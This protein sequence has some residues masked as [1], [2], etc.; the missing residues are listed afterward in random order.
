MASAKSISFTSVRCGLSN[1]LESLQREFRLRS[2]AEAGNGSVVPR[3]LGKWFCE[4]R[5]IVLEPFGGA[6]LKRKSLFGQFWQDSCHLRVPSH[7]WSR[8]DGTGS[9]G[10]STTSTFPS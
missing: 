1:D 10:Q 6:K 9:P 4:N 7:Q 5:T 3:I 2:G 8:E